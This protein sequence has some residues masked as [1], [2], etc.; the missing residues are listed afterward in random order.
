MILSLTKVAK[1][2]LQKNVSYKLIL[3]IYSIQKFELARLDYDAAA[4]AIGVSVRTVGRTVKKLA[5]EKLLV[6]EDNKLR[7]SKDLCKIG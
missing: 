4:D 6:I 1:A 3:H 7:L 5:D 2:L